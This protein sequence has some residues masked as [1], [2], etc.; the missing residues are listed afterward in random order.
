MALG[1][2]TI[3]LVED[4]ANDALFMKMALDNA[5][6]H[7]AVVTIA[8]GQ[9]ALNYLAGKGA[10]SN[11]TAHPIP[12]L[13]LLDLKLPHLMGL[14]VLQWIRQRP[15]L[16]TT[17]VIIISASANP[18]DIDSAYRLGANAYLVK[19]SSFDQLQGLARSL[20]EFWLVHNQRSLSRLG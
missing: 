4:D 18:E 9:E 6:V 1:S 7:E 8:D 14:N 13:V 3:L 10:Y 16:A 15:E 17:V 5:D 12:Y 11:R 19:P 20:K 2:T